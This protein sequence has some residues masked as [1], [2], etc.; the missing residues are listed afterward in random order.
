MHGRRVAREGKPRGAHTAHTFSFGSSCQPPHPTRS[1][2]SSTSVTRT[3]AT[4]PLGQRAHSTPGTLAS[5]ETEA[6]GAGQQRRRGC[7]RERRRGRHCQHQ[8]AQREPCPPHPP[9]LCEAEWQPR[10]RTQ[11]KH[12]ICRAA[13]GSRRAPGGRGRG[14]GAWSARWR[15]LSCC[16]ACGPQPSRPAAG[17]PR[18]DRRPGQPAARR[19]PRTA[20]RERGACGACCDCAAATPTGRTSKALCNRRC[21]APLVLEG[22]AR[23]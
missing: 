20:A 17:P 11:R 18:L 5:A 12:P 13:H 4:P 23:D 19:P 15:C 8:D 14:A 7:Q 9:R 22:Y 10:T 21:R 6:M 1:T 16:S 3:Y 2:H